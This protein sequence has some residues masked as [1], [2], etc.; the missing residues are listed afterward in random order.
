M[1]GA[2]KTQRLTFVIVKINQIFKTLFKGN[3][4]ADLGQNKKQVCFL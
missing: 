3:I 4:N 2:I 1:P